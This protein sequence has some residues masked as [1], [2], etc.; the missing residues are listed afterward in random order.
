KDSLDAARGVRTFL[1]G[2]PLGESGRADRFSARA[3]ASRP[4]AAATLVTV[5]S[6]DPIIRD[7]IRPNNP[8]WPDDRDQREGLAGFAWAFRGAADPSSTGGAGPSILAHCSSLRNG[9]GSRITR[10]PSW[11]PYA[12]MGRG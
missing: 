1:R 7:R 2:K 4:G 3:G 5:A 12:F 10:S 6:S 11:S 9:R 8:R